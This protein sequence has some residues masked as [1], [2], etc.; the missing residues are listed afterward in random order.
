MQNKQYPRCIYDIESRVRGM[1]IKVLEQGK[2]K[3]RLS[4][5]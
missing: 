5:G 2:R 4:K 3:E 1:S